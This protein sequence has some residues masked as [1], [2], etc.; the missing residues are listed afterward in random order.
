[1]IK[2]MINEKV[3]IM[4]ISSKDLQPSS[5]KNQHVNLGIN[6]NE[7]LLHCNANEMFN[8]GQKNCLMSNIKK[9]ITENRITIVLGNRTINFKEK[10]G[11]I[12]I[13]GRDHQPCSTDNHLV[14]LGINDNEMMKF[15]EGMRERTII[16][17]MNEMFNEGQKNSWGDNEMINEK[18]GIITIML[19]NR[20]MKFNEGTKGIADDELEH[21]DDNMIILMNKITEGIIA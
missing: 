16:G 8:E 19:R 7:I 2:M 21:D 13:S 9:R 18:V 3:E 4:T 20:T 14:E 17:K 15:N 6:D 1:M 10:I 11:M 5:T 12:T